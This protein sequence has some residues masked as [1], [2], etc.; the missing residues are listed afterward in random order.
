MSDVIPAVIY[1]ALSKKGDPDQASIDSQLDAVRA[2]LTNLDGEEVEIVRNPDGRDHFSDDGH[3]GSKKNRGPDLEEAICAAVQAAEQYGSSELWANTSARFGRGSGRKGKARSLLELFV[4]MRRAGV[5][6]RT[7]HDDE[8]V[9]NEMLIG[10]ASTQASK[11]SADLA[12]SVKRA[13]RRQAEHGQH[14]GGPMPLG[15]ML[16]GDKRVVEDPDHAPTVARIFD[17]AAQG[18]PDSALART[19][20]AEGYRTRPIKAKGTTKP[21]RPFDRRAVQAI[22]LN[23]FYS[24]RIAYDGELYDG[25]H[26]A[27]IEPA[28]FDAIQQARRQRDHAK[29]DQKVIGRPAQNHALAKLAHCGRCGE[30]LYAVTSTYRR[31]DGSRARSYECHNSKFATGMCDAK[32]INAEII[33][34][35]VIAGLD[36]L[37][38]DF[39][40]WRKRI[41][42]GHTTERARLATE[43]ERAQRDHDAQVN[44]T[45]KVEAKWSNYVAAG[46]DDKAD[47]VLPI[48]DRE[49]EA[50]V[51]AERRL[52]A[53]QHALESVPTEVPADAMLDFANA[54]QTA[55]K[56]RVD[57]TGTMAEV[58]QALHELFDHFT[59]SGEPGDG[60]FQG[61]FIQPWLR[62][63]LGLIPH[64]LRDDEAD[65]PKLLKSA[66]DMPPLRWLT[67]ETDP[68][69]NAQNAQL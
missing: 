53:S 29:P 55:I 27:L 36:T 66:S 46:E 65:W 63:D 39:E 60:P 41:E 49:R 37:L 25:Q 42:D 69:G 13:K 40:A 34:A 16:D 51:H 11:Y 6:L 12:E 30:R 20:N 10:F 33:D 5:T 22:V 28:A 3:S 1:A 45:S 68:E 52:L 54:L 32:P 57:P 23:A 35:A 17:L 50:A 44:K 62:D 8:F 47:L 9:Q 56:G 26:E 19:L 59:I 31:K 2:K 43:V 67:P 7:V 48:V 58:N 61:I 14:L 21:G 4:A 15:F 18:V 38:V 64:G 24:G